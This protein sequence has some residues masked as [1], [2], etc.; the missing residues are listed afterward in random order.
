MGDTLPIIEDSDWSPSEKDIENRDKWRQ[1]V[2]EKIVTKK[3]LQASGH[4]I[5]PLDV[6]DLIFSDGN[7]SEDQLG[8]IFEEDPL[9]N[10]LPDERNVLR[11]RDQSLAYAYGDKD[12]DI[13]RKETGKFAKN[14]FLDKNTPVDEI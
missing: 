2:K 1:L 8:A 5:N 12:I 14:R 13:D 3:A 7:I 4:K 9:I 10:H 6:D 11:P